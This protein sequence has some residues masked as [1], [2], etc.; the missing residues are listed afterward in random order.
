MVF[1]LPLAIT[2]LL[3]I[4]LEFF[5]PGGVMATGGAL[6]LLSS[7]YFFSVDSP[8]IFGIL[9]YVLGLA[10]MV[11]LMVRVALWKVKKVLLKDAA[12][13]RGD[14]TGFQASSFPEELVGKSGRADTDLG[15][16]GY[17]LMDGKRFQA[18]SQGEY[19]EKGSSIEII[20]GSGSCLFV[21]LQNGDL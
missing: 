5:L 10:L 20:G 16:S 6:L 8:G 9:A 3:L 19:I 14:Q 13:I 1:V 18:L 17:I 4:F 11:F 21:Q 12:S 7:V 15:P 2:G